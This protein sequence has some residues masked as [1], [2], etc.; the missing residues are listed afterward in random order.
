M[1]KAFYQRM[2]EKVA[3]KLLAKF[4]VS[5]TYT[6]LDGETTATGKVAFF[7]PD[8]KREDESLEREYLTESN[9]KGAYFLL[10]DRG[11]VPERGATITS[12]ESTRVIHSVEPI[13]PANITVIY[14]CLLEV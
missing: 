11:L 9:Q 4:G 14:E 7:K 6:S 5:M 1:S 10:D 8:R 3:W 12:G 13:A 2:R